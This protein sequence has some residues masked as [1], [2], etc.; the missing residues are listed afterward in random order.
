MSGRRATTGGNR[1]FL[2]LWCGAAVLAGT[3]ALIAGPPEDAQAEAARFPVA[4]VSTLPLA[5]LFS[6]GAAQE[7]YIDHRMNFDFS[8]GPFIPIEGSEDYDVGGTM[9]MKFQ[10]E[11]VPYFTVG[12]EFAYA[13]HG[14]NF[15]PDTFLDEGTLHRFFFLVP[16]E[17]DLPFAGPERNPF[18]VRF[19]VA[20]GIQV[21][22][23]V[24]DRRIQDAFTLE[25]EG[26]PLH[27]EE[28]AFVTWDIRL[29]AGLRFPLDPHFGFLF[30]VA[31]DLSWGRAERRFED[32]DT[33]Q[34]LVRDHKRLNLSG[35]SI[36]F[37]F[38][39]V[40]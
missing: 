34:T 22:D 40:F 28:D 7:Y 17:V 2:S 35:V 24:V 29:R 3:A 16:L 11:V 10:A 32:L 15:G 12:G 30:E 19:G 37:G 36:L 8:V 38:Q 25:P 23:P 20:P 21:V 33:G 18:S 27:L 6:A 5:Q 26:I 9:D 4:S 13:A 1:A 14:K 39:I 31:Y